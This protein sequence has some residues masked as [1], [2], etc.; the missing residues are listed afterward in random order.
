[1][2]GSSQGLSGAPQLRGPLMVM[3]LRVRTVRDAD[4]IVVLDQGRVIETGSHT[5]L[6]ARR[7]LYWYLNTRSA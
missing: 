5:D 4:V 2:E 6:M 1:M 7:G 3:A